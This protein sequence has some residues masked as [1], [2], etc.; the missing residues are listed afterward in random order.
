MNCGCLDWTICVRVHG[1]AVTV[2]VYVHARRRCDHVCVY[3]HMCASLP[4]PLGVH[5]QAPSHVFGT[6]PR[7]AEVAGFVPRGK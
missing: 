1:V 3:V 7:F 4:L 6:T 5:V 2:R